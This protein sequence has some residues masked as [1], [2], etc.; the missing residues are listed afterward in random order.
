MLHD[1]ARLPDPAALN[2]GELKRSRVT[3]IRILEAGLACLAET[4]YKKLSTTMVAE[5]A[6]ITRAAM[7]YHFGSRGEMIQAII[8]HVTRRRI[9]MYREAMEALPHDDD[10][11]G[12]A[13]DTAWAQLHTPE[14]AAFTELSLAARTDPE[15]AAMFAPAMAAF[16]RS[17]RK[18]ALALFPQALITGP[19]F[20]LRRDLVRFLMEGIVQQNGITF[21]RAARTEA[22]LRLLKMLVTTD[23]G[24]A[25]LQA[26]VVEPQGGDS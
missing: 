25:L 18:S 14:F 19:E 7:L 5:R 15:L 21:D 9:E 2:D 12:L 20:D 4:G 17:R 10:F 16:D 8:R 3:R 11:H 26:A 23:A 24:V 6:G 1:I 22:L 13:L